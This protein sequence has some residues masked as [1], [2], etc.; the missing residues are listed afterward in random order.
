MSNITKY[1]KEGREESTQREGRRWEGRKAGRLEENCWLC[2]AWRL[3]SHPPPSL[4]SCFRSHTPS[5]PGHQTRR[6]PQS[7]CALSRV[8]PLPGDPALWAHLASGLRPQLKISPAQPTHTSS[9]GQ[10]P[11]PTLHPQQLT[12]H[13]AGRSGRADKGNSHRA[14]ALHG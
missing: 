6:S 11:W 4:I 9:S 5:S 7:P 12:P 13:Q 14:Q 2:A 3:K 1:L 10:N 8:T